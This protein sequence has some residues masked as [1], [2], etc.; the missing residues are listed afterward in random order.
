MVGIITPWCREAKK[1]MIDQDLN[2][3]QL[4]AKVGFNRTYVSG[5]INGRII[6]PKV[7]EAISKCLNLETPYNNGL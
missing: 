6:Q 7:A 4:T 3:T 2:V 1:A 5:V